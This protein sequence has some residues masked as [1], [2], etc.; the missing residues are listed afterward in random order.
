MGE[1]RLTTTMPRYE[2]DQQTKII[3]RLNAQAKS[4]GCVIGTPIDPLQHEYTAAILGIP[5]GGTTMVAG[6][7]QRLGLY[8]GENLGYKL[9]DP[10][11]DKKPLHHMMNAIQSRN[12]AMRVWGWKFPE[13]ALYLENLM[14]HIR[15]PRIVVVWRDP[16]TAAVRRVTAS[17]KKSDQ[18]LDGTREVLKVVGAMVRRQM[19]NI[20]LLAAT[21]CP[22]YFI[23][24]EKAIR[25]RAQFIEQF[26]GFLGLP[27]PSNLDDLLEFMEPESYKLVENK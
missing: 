24:Y 3:R 10:D 5:R 9:E 17:Q 7:A 15:N 1:E 16:F 13:A 26:A 11:F 4:P 25:R 23:S 2:A 27:V 20:S 14:P 19:T 18:Q 6:I 21:Q 8:I 22:I 12:R